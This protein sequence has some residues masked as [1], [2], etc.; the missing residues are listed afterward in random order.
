MDQPP[1][2]YISCRKCKKTHPMN[3]MVQ[4]ATKAKKCKGTFNEE[5]VIS[6]REHSSEI[7]SAIKKFRD[8]ERY[9]RRKAKG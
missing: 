6:L 2:V 7:S 9:K 8:S 5:Q 1:S 3:S 4:H